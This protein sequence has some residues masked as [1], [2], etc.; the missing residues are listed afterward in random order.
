MFK[1]CKLPRV[2]SYKRYQWGKVVAN[3]CGSVHD[4]SKSDICTVHLTG[5]MSRKV[6][7]VIRQSRWTW[8][9]L[10]CMDPCLVP[11]QVRKSLGLWAGLQDWPVEPRLYP[12]GWIGLWATQFWSCYVVCL[13]CLSIMSRVGWLDD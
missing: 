3:P 1:G 9:L 6:R 13:G 12:N 4:L 2:V 10:G 11:D 5:V 7:L 8:A